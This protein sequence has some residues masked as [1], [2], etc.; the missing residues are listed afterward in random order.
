MKMIKNSIKLLGIVALAL[1]TLQWRTDAI[2]LTDLA[3][4][5]NC[6]DSNENSYV[7]QKYYTANNRFYVNWT[8]ATNLTMKSRQ[9]S[10]RWG[11]SCAINWKNVANGV[12][13]TKNWT[14]FIF[15]I[16]LNEV[17][18]YNSIVVPEA[19]LNY[20]FRSDWQYHLLN[21]VYVFHDSIVLYDDNFTHTLQFLWWTTIENVVL[22][23][24]PLT[25]STT[26]WL[27]NF[28]LIDFIWKKAY[29]LN[30]LA[31]HIPNLFF[32]Y[33]SEYNIKEFPYTS[34]YT[35]TPIENATAFPTF[36]W[37]FEKWNHFDNDIG[38]LY[39]LDWQ[40]IAPDFWGAGSTDTDD[41]ND[42]FNANLINN[43]NSCVN[44]WENLRKY[45][46]LMW[47]CYWQSE[48]WTLISNILASNG[49]YNYTG[50]L[51]YCQRLSQFNSNI[52]SAYINQWN[53]WSSFNEVNLQDFNA[54]FNDLVYSWFNN[55]VV[56]D[57]SWHVSWLPNWNAWCTAYTVSDFYNKEKSFIEKVSESLTD[58]FWESIADKFED[59]IGNHTT[60]SWLISSI[61]EW[62]SWFFSDYLFDPYVQQFNSWY[63]AF[64]TDLGINNCSN[65]TSSFSWM[66]FWNT[67]LYI[68]SAILIFILLM[69]L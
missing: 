64:H 38:F 47:Y 23:T 16:L 10:Q 25:S 39:T 9:N 1:A 12:K 57:S 48:D 45:L 22:F 40:F 46:Q 32:G 8:V 33:L 5:Y 49:Q 69:F 50:D 20:L 30:I 14:N 66:P 44:K 59:S 29:S 27:D 65:I 17:N 21:N 67:A 18:T 62:T 68:V 6:N 51:L 42:Y 31:Q 24:D 35:L 7:A 60:F 43:Y 19:W 26:N 3:V 41:N 61:S 2:A 55:S 63:N 15:Q 58:F 54:P 36:N 4:P 34:S 53:S 28:Y 52:Y 13:I 37:Y 11:S 56:I